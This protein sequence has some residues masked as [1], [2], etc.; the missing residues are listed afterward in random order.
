M[1][2]CTFTNR[3]SKAYIESL[4]KRLEALNQILQT[5]SSGPKEPPLSLESDIEDEDQDYVILEEDFGSLSLTGEHGYHGKS[6][7]T[8]L[9]QT[10][11][12]T[13]TAGRSSCPRLSFLRSERSF[14]WNAYPWQPPS[15]PV[16]RPKKQYSFPPEDLIPELIDFY[17]QQ[18]N[19]IFPLLHRP[20][21]TQNV[22]D[23]LHLHDEKFGAILLVV[24][25]LGSRYSDDPRALAEGETSPLSNGW[26]WFNQISLL[27]DS[28]FIRASLH[29]LQLS[30]LA[31]MFLEA[32]TAPQFCWTIIAVSLRL[33]QDAG[34]HRRRHQ[35]EPTVEAELWRRVWW[36]LIALD[37]LQATSMGRSCA[38]INDDFDLDMPIECDDE[39]WTLGF[40]QPE[41]KPSVVSFFV[42]FS[43]LMDTQ[44]RILRSLYSSCSSKRAIMG[45]S[46][47][48]YEKYTVAKVVA[49]LENWLIGLP[50]HLRWDPNRESP[51][52]Y[53]QSAVLHVVYHHANILLHRAFVAPP[54][55]ENHLSAP[56][57]QSCVQSAQAISQIINP[58]NQRKA[59]ALPIVVI[60][61]VAAAMM[62]LIDMWDAQ[63]RGRSVDW[64]QHRSEVETLIQFVKGAEESCLEAG[65][66]GDILEVLRSPDALFEALAHSDWEKYRHVPQEELIPVNFS[67][68]ELQLQTFMDYSTSVFGD[69]ILDQMLINNLTIAAFDRKA[70]ANGWAHSTGLWGEYFLVAKR[71]GII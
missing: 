58:K 10:A 16:P 54:S 23:G 60:P 22:R 20:T 2:Q 7:N 45:F 65:K 49:N 19:I 6:S 71:A 47:P 3:S 4:E 50:E 61:A 38:I 11:L 36:V 21:F 57:L 25:A 15:V 46:G 30:C 44:V 8:M 68:P 24:C 67:R 13:K 48:E 32:G 52:F 1:N 33:A 41:H 31:V 55:K 37:R 14:F 70:Q 56:A 43:R 28:W 40:R 29:D 17:F 12:Q 35:Q 18:Y 42:C 66:L 64:D 26:K 59:P 51:L 5:V 34:F 62:L 63:I 27:H 39:Y 69:A 53:T 9:L